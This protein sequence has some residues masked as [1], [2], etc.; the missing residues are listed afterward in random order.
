MSNKHLIILNIHYSTSSSDSTEIV[1]FKDSMNNPATDYYGE[2]SSHPVRKQDII[3]FESPSPFL[4]ISYFP[5]DWQPSGATHGPV[6]WTQQ[7]GSKWC[8]TAY[9]EPQSSTSYALEL[10]VVTTQ[11]I[12]PKI[13]YPTC[14]RIAGLEEIPCTTSTG[15]GRLEKTLAR[16]CLLVLGGVGT[17][18]P[19][20]KPTIHI[21]A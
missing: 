14:Y 21:S 2:D 1:D 7:S 3:R 9:S 19:V 13:P 18:S 17:K 10:V 8:L 11:S 15:P 16:L 6:L 4:F 5:Q 12:D 20:G